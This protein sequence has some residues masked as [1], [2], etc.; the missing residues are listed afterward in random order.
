MVSEGSLIRHMESHSTPL[1]R[2]SH[3][4][5][6]LLATVSSLLILVLL[7]ATPGGWSTTANA[8]DLADPA[9]DTAPAAP[10]AALSHSGN[11]YFAQTGHSLQ[12]G[13]LSYWLW[14]GQV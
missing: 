7:T 1:P 4:S 14:H 10:P 11:I 13:F 9:A 8:S 5:P 12:N 2:S 6:R 3:V